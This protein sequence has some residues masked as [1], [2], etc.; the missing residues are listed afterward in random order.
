VPA[1]DPPRLPV[2]W[3]SACTPGTTTWRGVLAKGCLT[4]EQLE[5][6]AAFRIA[7]EAYKDELRL[8]CGTPADGQPVPTKTVTR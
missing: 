1:K 5:A 7:D 4:R 8:R 6:A 2:G 3:F